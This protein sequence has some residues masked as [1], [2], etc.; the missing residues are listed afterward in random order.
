MEGIVRMFGMHMSMLLYS[1]WITS[2]DLLQSTWNSAQCYVPDWM[3]G[4]AGG[5][6][7]HVYVRLS[8]FA[9]H[10]TTT[11]LLTGYALIQNTK[12]KV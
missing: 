10:Q 9:V 12:F 7:I 4:G 8:P 11:T 5:E 2:K 3:G 1:K 6:C